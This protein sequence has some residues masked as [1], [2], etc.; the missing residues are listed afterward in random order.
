MYEDIVDRNR[1]MAEVVQDAKEYSKI[2][3]KDFEKLCGLQCTMKEICFFFG[4]SYATLHKWCVKEYGK[5]FNEV[6]EDKRCSGLISLRRKQFN[7][8][9]KNAN[10]AIFLGKNY[11]GQRDKFDD[12]RNHLEEINS[13][14]NNIADLINNPQ[15]DRSEDDV[16]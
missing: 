10:M 11:L 2:N 12:E 15:K 3:Y 16:Q 14:I 1:A 5:E 13:A 6:Y 8:A 4:I 7:L 9:D